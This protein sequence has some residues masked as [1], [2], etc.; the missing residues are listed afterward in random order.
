MCFVGVST[1]SFVDDR[2]NNNTNACSDEPWFFLDSTV[3]VLAK[4]THVAVHRRAFF[5]T[6]SV[7]LPAGTPYLTYVASRT[8]SGRYC[9]L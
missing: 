2:D 9:N 3:L 7:R 8:S 6:I 1:T 4:S 5:E